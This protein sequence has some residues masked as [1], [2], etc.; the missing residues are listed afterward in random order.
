MDH[1]GSKHS[2]PKNL[3]DDLESLLNSGSAKDVPHNG[4]EKVEGIYWEGTEAGL[5]GIPLFP[6]LI[7]AKDG[8][9]KRG[10]MGDSTGTKAK[11]EASAK[12]AEM[13]KA[14]PP[15]ERN[16]QRRAS[17]LKT[18]GYM[19]GARG[20]GFCLLTLNDVDGYSEMDWRRNQSN[21]QGISRW[22]HPTGNP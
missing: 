5:M 4:T 10:N 1:C 20:H 16:T 18:H 13:R 14:H 22:R 3:L 2:I 19:P 17:P 8:S 12:W 15:T 9:Q 21:H 7:Y 6:G 11:R